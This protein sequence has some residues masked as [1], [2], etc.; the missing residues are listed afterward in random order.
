ML[1]ST[2]VAAASAI[3]L[4]LSAPAADAA[5]LKCNGIRMKKEWSQ[6]SGSDQ[7]K[8][9]NAV[10]NLIA[11]QDVGI[12]KNNPETMSF[13]DFTAL[14]AQAA[15]Y[16]H[17]TAQ[18][19]PFHRVMMW[20][21]DQAIISAGGPADGSP[22]WDWSMEAAMLAN[23]GDEDKKLLQFQ[24]GSSIFA[25]DTFG[26]SGTSQS[27]CVKGGVFANYVPYQE[28]RPWNDKCLRRINSKGW[29]YT[30]NHINEVIR[31]SSTYDQFRG[32]SEGAWH[33]SNHF[34]IGGYENGS[35]QGDMAHGSVS[36]NDIAF[37]FH[38]NM[39]DK[40]WAR[41][42]QACKSSRQNDYSGNVVG[43]SNDNS[44]SI[45]DDVF[46]FDGVFKVADVMNTED[47]CYNYATNPNN[48]F[49]MDLGC[50]DAATTTAA[51]STTSSQA[52]TQTAN[53]LEKNWFPLLLP[54]LFPANVAF[55]PPSF[56]FRRDS[57]DSIDYSLPTTTATYNPVTSTQ[58]AITLPPT[59]TA[60]AT[61]TAV[62]KPA[63]TP[64]L[65][66]NCGL[67]TEHYAPKE[68]NVGGINVQ[69]PE[70][71]KVIYKDN[72][73]VKVVP[74]DYAFNATTGESNYPGMWP[75][76]I[77][78]DRGPAPTYTPTNTK[79]T[80]PPYAHPTALQYPAMPPKEYYEA[81]G[82]DYHGAMKAY[83]KAQE[84]TDKYNCDDTIS[85]ASL[86][87]VEERYKNA[88]KTAKK[89][90]AKSY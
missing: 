24:S 27:P 40:I 34:L 68:V 31:S 81:M 36:P 80:P 69:I 61:T 49:I 79:C 12:R 57:Y 7:A 32:D 58:D 44:A 43:G 59:K 86:Q 77:Y 14:H 1:F 29:F 18:F 38:H 71:K 74:V 21:W 64:D 73:V 53:A 51:T 45:N 28:V 26:K 3:A 47:L 55:R 2:I 37:Y 4:I 9:I 46:L 54:Q 82:M 52:P 5:K 90:K 6:L 17:S 23:V 62:A 67:I 33:S 11:R 56:L 20:A 87:K 88:T 19:Y 83:A 25:T 13:R 15:P 10:K 76:A 50:G 89:C 22:E 8:Y 48:D 30:P 42:Q 72:F 39:V 41:W 66:T 16:V 65:Q 35:P 85:A 75:T 84:I 70:G 78:P 60:Y 63:Y